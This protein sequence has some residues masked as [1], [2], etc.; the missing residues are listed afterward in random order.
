MKCDSHSLAARSLKE[1]LKNLHFL[2]TSVYLRVLRGEF[3]E[4]NFT[5]EVS[6]S[7]VPLGAGY[8]S[9]LVE[10]FPGCF[11]PVAHLESSWHRPVES[12]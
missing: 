3:L 11:R 8:L 10:A 2:Y 12:F 1:P 6:C 5:T 4:E 7:E 9:M